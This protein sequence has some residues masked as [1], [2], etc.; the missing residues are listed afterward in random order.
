MG[1]MEKQMRPV[2]VGWLI[3]SALLGLT[4]QAHAEPPIDKA[5]YIASCE[6]GGGEDKPKKCTCVADKIEAT[7]KDK[8]LEFAWHAMTKTVAELGKVQSGLSEAQEDEVIDKSFT[9]MTECG[10]EP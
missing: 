10:I 9:L 3:T 1:S 8:Q 7:F 4:A 6:S 5:A 2:R